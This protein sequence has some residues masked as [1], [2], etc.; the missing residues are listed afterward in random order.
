[1]LPLYLCVISLCGCPLTCPGY[2]G[3][4]NQGCTCYMNSLM[5]QLFMM[6]KFRQGKIKIS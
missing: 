4:K 2:V 6:P 5:Q 1:M 3:L